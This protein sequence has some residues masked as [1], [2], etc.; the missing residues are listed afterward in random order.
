MILPKEVRGRTSAEEGDNCHAAAAISA[1]ASH[2]I[3]YRISLSLASGV[4]LIYH[5]EI[6]HTTDR[7]PDGYTDGG[8]TIRPAA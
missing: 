4:H 7:R 1:G 3:R 2:E 5:I 8:T 6:D